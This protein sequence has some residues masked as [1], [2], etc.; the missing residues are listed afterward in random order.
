MTKDSVL[1]FS[2]TKR[3]TLYQGLE[4]GQEAEKS[5]TTIGSILFREHLG[6][7]G[8]HVD[9]IGK[10]GV[11]DD[12]DYGDKHLSKLGVEADTITVYDDA[13][14]TSGFTFMYANSTLE[15]KEGS[16]I[17]SY[18][19]NSCTTYDAPDMFSC[20]KKNEKREFRLSADNILAYF[21][22]QYPDLDSSTYM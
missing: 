17:K 6:I 12:F 4:S 9:I 11:S 10:I 13:Q 15:M 2:K 7:K 5:T 3:V 8:T 18:W 19:E 14:I 1:D 21:N 22:E 16:A 20:M